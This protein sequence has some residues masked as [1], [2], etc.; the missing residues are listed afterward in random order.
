MCKTAVEFKI[1]ENK[2]ADIAKSLLALHASKDLLVSMPEYILP[3]NLPVGSRE[4]ALYLTYAISIDYMTDAEK[5][6]RNSRGANELYP[7]RFTPEKILAVRDTSLRI[8]LRKLGARYSATAAQVWKKISQVLVEKYEG[9]PRNITAQPQ[10]IEKIKNMLKDFPNLRG[11][12]LANFY[13]RAMGE[14]GLLKVRNLQELDIP[15]DKQVARFTSY[16]GVITLQSPKF[17]G[18]VNDYPLRSII[19][20]AWRNA[21]RKHGVPPW[22]LDEPIWNIGS[23]LCVKRKCSQCPVEPHCNKTNGIAFREN[24]IIWE[25]AKAETESVYTGRYDQLVL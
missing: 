1:D 9:D 22:R 23:K 2:A 14:T 25:K 20:E 18:C 8:F 16:T 11:P 3:R 13:I 12:K 6:W 19:Q 7:E 4:H 15:V 21:A 10:T 17:Q 24:I 5:L